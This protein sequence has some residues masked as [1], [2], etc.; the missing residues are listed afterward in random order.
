MPIKVNGAASA[1]QNLTADLQF[2]ILY[3]TSV[4]AFTDPDANPPEAEQQIRGVNILV[5]DHIKDQSQKNFE[6]LFQTLALRAAPVIM[7]NPT[8]EL[9]LAAAGAP[10]L[11][12][13]GFS[14]KFALERGDI[15]Q[16]FQTGDPVGLLIRDLDGVI[17]AS[18]VRITTVVGSPSGVP[19]N[20]EFIRVSN[21]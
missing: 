21:L 9:S 19:L 17:I 2:Y 20:M 3:C 10:T 16:N 15:W 18:G 12:G 13:E 8:A 4:G 1:Q 11:T 7:N 14:W 6:I 5:T